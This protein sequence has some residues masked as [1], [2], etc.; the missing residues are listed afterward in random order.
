MTV[1][2]YP[3]LKPTFDGL[4]RKV[5]LEG[6]SSFELNHSFIDAILSVRVVHLKEWLLKSSD[7]WP[8]LGK[9]VIFWLS[10][11]CNVFI[12][13]E[14]EVGGELYKSFPGNARGNGKVWP[15]VPDFRELIDP[16]QNGEANKGFYFI[17]CG[18]LSW[19]RPITRMCGRYP[20][21]S[22]PIHFSH[23]VVKQLRSEQGHKSCC[24]IT[25]EM[26]SEPDQCTVE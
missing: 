22:I 11:C 6:G 4:H 12:V 23:Y 24:G 9:P 3:Y 19:R 10:T 13:G 8:Y 21:L 14:V 1:F 26:G 17:D 18:C 5:L 15:V 20:P 2:P 16:H 25:W 7:D